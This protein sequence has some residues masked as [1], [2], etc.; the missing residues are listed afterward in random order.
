M[1]ELAEVEFFRRQWD[2]GIGKKILRVELHPGA[3]IFRGTNP[4][5]LQKL[6]EGATLIESMA[7]GKQMAFRFSSA[8]LGLHLGMTGELRAQ[9][10]HPSGDRHD[11]LILRWKS[12]S[13]FFRDPRL[14]GRIR[15]HPSTTIPEWWADRPPNLLSPSFTITKL[16][17]YLKR[18]KNAPLKA[19]LLQQEQF[20]GIGNWMADEI[21]WRCQLPPHLPLSA[22]DTATIAKLRRIIREVCRDALRVVGASWS[23]PPAHWLFPHRWKNG[24]TCPRCRQPLKRKKIGGRTTCWCPACQK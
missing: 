13:L 20:P 17:E 2:P 10:G 6:L 19:T 22:T 11:H 1:P 9:S 8:W 18:R 3:R 15:F 16:T 21:L 23:D 24:G 5:A 4:P 7:H 14:F 12:G